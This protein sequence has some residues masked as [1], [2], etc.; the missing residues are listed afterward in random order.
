[1][2]IDVKIFKGKD[3]KIDAVDIGVVLTV[4][5]HMNPTTLIP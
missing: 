1:M 5:A 3:N 2:G 4:N